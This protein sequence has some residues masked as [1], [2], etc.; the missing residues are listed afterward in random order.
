MTRTG[1]AWQTR[2][3]IASDIA[4][5]REI[6][7]LAEAEGFRFVT[8]FLDDLVNERVCLD[9][10]CEFFLATLH[11]GQLLAIGG[12]TPDPYIDDSRVGRL[13]HVYVRADKRRTGLG[14]TLV[15]QLERRAAACYDR[16]RLRTDN[17]AAAAF[18]ER[19]GYEAV[20]SES[21]THHRLLSAPSTRRKS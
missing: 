13:R 14:R 4:A 16:L 10:P 7:A 15:A 11:G 8:R 19:V 9:A 6:A 20:A 5:L 21:S 3:L 12:V 18:Y 17:P 1:V 2:P